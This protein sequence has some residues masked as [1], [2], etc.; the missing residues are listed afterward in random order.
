MPKVGEKHFSYDAG[1]I[2]AAKDYA[3]E[4]GQNVID[5]R[6]RSESYHLGGQVPNQPNLQPPMGSQPNLQNPMDN[7]TDLQHPIDNQPNLQQSR[8]KH[9]GKVKYNK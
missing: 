3:K 1:G 5:A 8:Y 4:T 9:G 6:G 7:R 2:K